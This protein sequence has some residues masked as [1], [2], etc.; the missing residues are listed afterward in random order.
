MRQHT[1]M[2][3]HGPRAPGIA[4]SHLAGACHDLPRET[5]EVALL[6]TSEIVT[7][8]VRYGDGDVRMAVAC[9][10][11]LRVE[12]QD[13]ASGMPV[14]REASALAEGGRGLMIV[15]AFADAW[16]TEAHGT[17][18]SVWFSLR[19]PREASRHSR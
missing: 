13:H 7:N 9:N 14:V 11:D 5:V 2:L 12:V 17:S 6:L 19:T 10:G 4:R 16:G 1:W 15:A 3:Q 8:A 18:K